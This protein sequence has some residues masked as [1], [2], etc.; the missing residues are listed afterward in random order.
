MKTGIGWLGS[1]V[2][3][4][5]VGLAFPSAAALAK[6]T[7]KGMQKATAAPTAAKPAKNSKSMHST[8]HQNAKAL[9]TSGQHSTTKSHAHSQK[10]KKPQTQ[11]S[12]TGQT[13]THSLFHKDKSTK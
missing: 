3:V 5:L 9:S 11:K 7:Q 10:S 4:A 1:A 12:G 8:S 13:H 6:T 2:I